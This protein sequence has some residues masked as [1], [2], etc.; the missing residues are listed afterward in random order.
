MQLLSRINENRKFNIVLTVIIVAACLCYGVCYENIGVKTVSIVLTVFVLFKAILEQKLKFSVPLLFLLQGMVLAAYVGRLTFGADGF[1][2]Y[3]A[4]AA[5]MAYLAGLVMVQSKDKKQAD[6]RIL[7]VTVALML[8]L[9]THGIWGVLATRSEN[10]L[11]TGY[12]VLPINKQLVFP[13]QLA[14]DFIMITAAVIFAV[15]TFKNNK[16]LSIAIISAAVISQVAVFKLY[17]SFLGISYFKEYTYRWPAFKQ[18]VILTRMQPKGNFTITEGGA[19][20]SFNMW[21]DYARDY[22]ITTFILLWGFKLMTFAA[23]I[24]M[25]IRD[26]SESKIKWLIVPVYIGLNFFYSFESIAKG[27]I[28]YWLFAL[29]IAGMIEGNIKIE[30]QNHGVMIS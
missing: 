9:Y 17:G 16:V 4:V 20:S 30:K 10:C 3:S 18:A 25:L 29:V 19:F 8:G 13:P 27:Q 22:G 24:L 1:D 23:S 7:V 2:T 21:L 12:A 11:G 14:F 6:T 15:V 5:I 28:C 26:K